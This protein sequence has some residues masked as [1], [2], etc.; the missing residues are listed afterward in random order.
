MSEPDESMSL[1]KV[2]PSIVSYMKQSDEGANGDE[3]PISVQEKQTHINDVQEKIE[4]TQM[5]E[6]MEALNTMDFGCA[7]F[8]EMV[9]E[10]KQ[11]FWCIKSES[12]FAE[13]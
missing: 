7:Y 5:Q 10:S 13:L 9:G 4:L 11:A 1:G 12:H 2:I 6:E 3:E 8:Q